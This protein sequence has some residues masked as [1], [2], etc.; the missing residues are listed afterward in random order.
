MNVREP[1]GATLAAYNAGRSA[2]SRFEKLPPSGL[3]D[4]FLRPLAVLIRFVVAPDPERPTLADVRA[5]ER[6]E[7]QL[8]DLLDRQTGFLEM[9]PAAEG[10]TAW[11][12]IERVQSELRRR[13]ALIAAA[14]A[15]DDRPG[16]ETLGGQP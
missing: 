9:M 11:A 2:A 7:R 12:A 14:V 4:H 3:A 1:R 16:S 8:L 10:L 13:K 6:A 15:G 5:L